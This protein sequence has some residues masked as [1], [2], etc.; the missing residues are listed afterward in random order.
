MM[1]FL[2]DFCPYVIVALVLFVLGFNL[3]R[4][5]N[6][7]LES[8]HE[9]VSLP[10]YSW[11]AIA[12]ILLIALFSAL[13]YYT[14]NDYRMYLTNFQQLQADGSL[15]RGNLEIG[16][17]LV[18]KLIALTGCHFTVYFG[19]WG[20]LQA[21]CL[22]YGLRHHKQLYCWI[23]LVL[24]LGPF[25]INWLTYLRQWTIAIAFVPMVP[26]FARRKFWPCLLFTL[27][28]VTIHYSAW[29]LMLL[30]FVPL[31]LKADRSRNFYLAIFAVCYLLCTYPVWLS[32]IVSSQWVFALV[33][34]DKYQ[35]LFQPLIEHHFV[36]KGFGPLRLIYLFQALLFIWYYPAMREYY[37][38]DKLFNAFFA[39]AFVGVCYQHLFIN[40]VYA[41]TRP[42]DYLF[43]FVV[44]M[45]AYVFD[46]FMAIK[47]KFMLC[48]SCLVICSFTFISCYKEVYFLCKPA[49]ECNLLYHFMT[50]L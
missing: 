6:R 48:V 18:T 8:T 49:A 11:E 42:A 32:P 39:L 46:Y 33:G 28:A 1:E 3:S 38:R 26:Y 22:Y 13:R 34:Y 47:K 41:L 29:I 14:G 9:A 24:L 12:S 4:R 16:F 20:A 15:L 36:F 17:V 10:W 19:F 2:I 31:V 35:Y 44:I 27:V 45:M 50:W 37:S 43:I 40:T 5:E 23:G 30:Y 21:F 7:L 25:C